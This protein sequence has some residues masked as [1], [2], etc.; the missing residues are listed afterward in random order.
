MFTWRGGQQ[1]GTGTYW[2]VSTGDRIE[3][4]NQGMLPGDG[5]T[6]YIKAPSALV[7][8]FAPVLGLLYAIFLPFIGIAM[9]VT[10]IGKK[11]VG[12]GKKLAV[13]VGRTAVRGMVDAAARSVSFGWRPVKAYLAGKRKGRKGAK[14][15]GGADSTK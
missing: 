3:M 9:T 10:L 8:L 13:G 15:K 14:D 6:T 4:E 1:A 2:D 5:G 11:A 7:L 12:A